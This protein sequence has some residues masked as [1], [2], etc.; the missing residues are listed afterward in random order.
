MST[1]PHRITALIP[2][3]DRRLLVVTYLASPASPPAQIWWERVVAFGVVHD[4]EDGDSVHT[5]IRLDTDVVDAESWIDSKDRLGLVHTS[6]R[7]AELGEKLLARAIE[8]HAEK[9]A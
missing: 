8:E 3:A 6:E 4:V 5:F 9:Q 1:G 7:T 2:A